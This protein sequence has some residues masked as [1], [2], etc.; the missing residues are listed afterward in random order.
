MLNATFKNLYCAT[1]M[2]SVRNLLNF[3][4]QKFN[5]KR[6]EVITNLYST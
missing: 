4:M 1:I 3:T 6:C 5:F 2:V